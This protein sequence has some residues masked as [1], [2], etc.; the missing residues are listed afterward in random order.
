MHAIIPKSQFYANGT[1][2]AQNTSKLT[3]ENICHV[4]FFDLCI[5]SS[6]AI[7]LRHTCCVLRH[8]E[9]FV[10]CWK[11]LHMSIAMPREAM[12]TLYGPYINV[13]KPL[14]SRQCACSYMY[15]AVQ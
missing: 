1:N 14:P 12:V 10:W 15:Y 6:S 7:A 2:I 8:M 11:F 13:I 5:I 9:H 4:F 3:T